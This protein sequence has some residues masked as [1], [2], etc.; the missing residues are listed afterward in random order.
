MEETETPDVARDVEITQMLRFQE[1]VNQVTVVLML[2]C[3]MD[4][5]SELC[6]QA[7]RRQYDI[8]TAPH[9]MEKYI[10]KAYKDK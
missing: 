1:V 10:N 8:T 7:N 2:K 6:G 4:T 9:C 5:R 3:Y